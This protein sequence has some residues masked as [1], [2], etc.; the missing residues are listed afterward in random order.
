L[1]KH[2]DRKSN[3]LL[4]RGD[5]SRAGGGTARGRDQ[6]ADRQPKLPGDR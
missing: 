4:D 1:T 3:D 6:C 5:M 2:K